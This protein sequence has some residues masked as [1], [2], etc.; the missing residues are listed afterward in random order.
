MK[1]YVVRLTDK[2]R[3]KLNAMITK[4]KS[5]A[6]KIRHAHILLKADADGPNWSD[7]QIA[8]AFSMHFKTVAGVRER[9]V[10]RG[11]EGTLNRKKQARPPK[12]PKFDGKAEARLIALSRSKAP[13]GCARWTLRLLADKAVELE[14]VE[15][16]S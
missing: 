1:R 12:L 13:E 7:E 11:L 10:E 15:S 6:Y 14:I 9:F 16:V 5:A 8:K 3:E 2:E 4:G